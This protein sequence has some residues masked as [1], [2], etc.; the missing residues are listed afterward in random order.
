MIGKRY[1]TMAEDDGDGYRFV[2][3]KIVWKKATTIDFSY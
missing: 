1:A 2:G 3:L